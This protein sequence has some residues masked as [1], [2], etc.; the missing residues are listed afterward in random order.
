MIMKKYISLI[1]LLAVFSAL[2]TSC[3]KD[4]NISTDVKFSV[5]DANGGEMISFYTTSE[6]EIY[7]EWEYSSDNPQLFTYFHD[8]KNEQAFG[9]LFEKKTASYRTLILQPVAE[10]EANISFKTE[11]GDKQY[12]FKL[13]VT[14]KD[15]V[16]KI[17]GE[18]IK[19]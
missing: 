12:N 14:K 15:G 10:G 13:T 2:L 9:K 1:L 4:E 8:S 6:K 11:H 18:E 7:G 16:F 5:Y 17:K 19:D 3:S